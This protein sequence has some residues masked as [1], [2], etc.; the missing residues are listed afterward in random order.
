MEQTTNYPLTTV[1][2]I[3]GTISLFFVYNDASKKRMDKGND[4]FSAHMG[5][6]RTVMHYS[7]LNAKYKFFMD[8]QNPLLQ[9]YDLYMKDILDFFKNAEIPKRFKPSLKSLKIQNTIK[10]NKLS[11][12]L[13]RNKEFIEYNQIM[14]L[15]INQQ[16]ISYIELKG[17]N[18]NIC[19]F[20]KELASHEGQ[21]FDEYMD[22]WCKKIFI[23]PEFE[24]EVSKEKIKQKIELEEKR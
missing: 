1:E 3:G 14:E 11:E 9:K 12:Y 2:Q 22:D 4:F 6:Y 20:L 19:Q 8:I 16:L 21:A 24:L 13:L 10:K 17:L 23:N 18:P 7:N 15:Q 5:H